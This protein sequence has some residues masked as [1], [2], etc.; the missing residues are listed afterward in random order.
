[1][2]LWAALAAEHQIRRSPKVYAEGYFKFPFAV[3]LVL[4]MPLGFYLAYRYADWSLMYFINPPDRSAIM[5]LSVVTAYTASFIVG[6]RFGVMSVRTSRI[7]LGRGVLIAIGIGQGVFC[8]MTWSRLMNVGTFSQFFAGE[9]IPFADERGLLLPN[10][11]IGSLYGALMTYAL[12]RSY[13]DGR[14]L[15][16]PPSGS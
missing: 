11:F 15:T 10:I 1:M 6:Y 7:G 4:F 12:A 9:T 3:S 13:R 16:S 2:G 14:R 8:L 5:G